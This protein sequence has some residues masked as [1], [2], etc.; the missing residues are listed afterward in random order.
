MRFA[1]P[2]FL[3]V[4][5]LGACSVDLV[6]PSDRICDE[7]HPC[8]SGQ[9][10]RI[11][12]CTSTPPEDWDTDAGA[13]AGTG[14]TDAGSSDGGSDAG[15]DAGVDAGVVV[16]MQPDSWAMLS[17]TQ[18]HFNAQVSGTV[19]TR[20]T[21]DYTPSAVGGSI[22]SEGLFTAPS[23]PGAYQVTATS[24]ADPTRSAS[25]TVTVHDGP[26]ATGLI[27]H[28]SADRLLG[29]GMTLPTDGAPVSEWKDLSG[30]GH[31]LTQP[32]S[33]LQPVFKANAIKGLPT[34]VFDGRDD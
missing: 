14:E 33:G 1:L 7:L 25:A 31:H 32:T 26:P 4:G 12:T 17:A 16:T 20:V 8:Q 15:E 3:L 21:W 19:D 24:M 18:K 11:D 6:S 30:N 27:V 13:D 10:C 28:Y 34:V 2:L 9:W 22:N 29:E 23:T 5:A